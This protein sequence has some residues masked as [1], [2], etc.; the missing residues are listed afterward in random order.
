MGGIPVAVPFTLAPAHL[1]RFWRPTTVALDMGSDAF[2]L[3]V[4]STRSLLEIPARAVVDRRG[5]IVA[6]G[7]RALLMAERLP[8]GCQNIPPMEMG[9]L[10]HPQAAGL[11][12][13]VLLRQLQRRRLWKP[14]LRV[15]VPVGMTP[16]ERTVLQG[17]LHDLP[18][19]DVEF[20]PGA[21]SQC[22]G[23]GLD[24][25]DAPGRL[26]LDIGAQRTV[27]TVLS[28]G[29]PVSVEIW[30]VGGD[31]WTL[32]LRGAVEDTYRVRVPLIVVEQWKRAG[33]DGRLP[34]QDR[35]CGHMTTLELPAAFAAAAME[36]ATLRLL[37]FIT[38]LFT[39]AAPTL[40]MVM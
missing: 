3:A 11:L 4:A 15:A 18:V 31:S 1:A 9:H 33:G 7:K 37:E 2:R 10:C 17:F 28:F 13:R 19:R 24:P 8:D 25:A 35:L 30:P 39:R 23:A 38:A 32:A 40:R 26:V 14:R 16:M 20:G 27:A 12:V 5:N 6:L 22:L 21:V 36:E 29:Q 34:V